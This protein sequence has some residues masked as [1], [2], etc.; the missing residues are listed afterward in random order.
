MDLSGLTARVDAVYE[1]AAPPSWPDPHAAREAAPEECSRVTDPQRYRVAALRA[2][3]WAEVLGDLPDVDA[4]PAGADVL[5]DRFDRGVRLVPRR[6]GTLPLLLLERDGDDADVPAVVVSMAE[7]DV[8]LGRMPDCGC[9]ACD[10]GSEDVLD[11]VDETILE[12]LGGVVVM[13]GR[14][15]HGTWS[16]EG[17]GS[18]GRPGCPEH[19]QVMSWGRRL[20]RGEPVALPDGAQAWVSASWLTTLRPRRR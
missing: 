5:S 17:G 1:R 6:P 9:D 14:H 11:G 8:E 19:D 10:V 3:A 2:R 18:G 12:A 13:R 16:P 4:G 7:P 20:A 15:W